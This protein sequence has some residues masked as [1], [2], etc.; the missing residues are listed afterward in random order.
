VDEDKIGGVYPPH[1]REIGSGPFART[2]RWIPWAAVLM[3]A[4]IVAGVVWKHL[5]G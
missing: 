4:A 3:V 5:P 2:P 1:P